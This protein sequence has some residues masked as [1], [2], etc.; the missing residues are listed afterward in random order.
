M[1]ATALKLYLEAAGLDQD[2]KF[3]SRDID[4]SVG[5]RVSD[6]SCTLML[7]T[8]QGA[9]FLEPWSYMLC[10]CLYSSM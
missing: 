2:P 1:I 3:S 9:L 5:L 7:A 4:M 10:K 6:M 8:K